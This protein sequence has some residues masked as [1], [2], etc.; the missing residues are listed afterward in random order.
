MI[1]WIR[2]YWLLV[3]LFFIVFPFLLNLAV[4][5]DTPIDVKVA[6]EPKDWLMFWGSYISSIASLVMVY[7]TY[8]IIK[9][10]DDI[11]QGRIVCDIIF[12]KHFYFLKITNVG[13]SQAYDIKI[14]FNNEF[15]SMINELS[16]LLFTKIQNRKF[17]LMPNESKHVPIECGIVGLHQTL[18]PQT[19]Q[20]E[21]VTVTADYLAKLKKE[22][23]K[24]RGSYISI[25]KTFDIS[26]NLRIDNFTNTPFAL[27]ET[28]T[29]EELPKIRKALEKLANKK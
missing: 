4:T 8:H 14:S 10:N 3:L 15:N 13:N 16:R 24:I 7:Y 5:C 2:K 22:E 27:V 26:Y 6:G 23:L 1:N 11:R 25:G 12:Y 18:N 29:N 9:Q 19:D 20:L 21:S 28:E 17:S